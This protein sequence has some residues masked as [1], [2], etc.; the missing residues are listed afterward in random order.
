ATKWH[1][2][3]IMVSAGIATA[4]GILV[5]Q[6]WGRRDASSAKTVNMLA[7]K[8]GTWLM[9]PLTF[10]ITVFSGYIMLLQT[11]DPD[12]ISL[13]STYLWYSIPVLVLT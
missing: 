8:Y 5:A 11:S 7:L 6:Y 3:I 4:N 2:V 9:V 13:G 1:F 12:V 10:I